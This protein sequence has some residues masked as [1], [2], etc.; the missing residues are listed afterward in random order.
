MELCDCF[1]NADPAESVEKTYV[2]SMIDFFTPGEHVNAC[3]KTCTMIF[4]GWIF[5]CQ[6]ATIIIGFEAFGKEFAV[7]NKH[8]DFVIQIN[9]TDPLPL[10][11]LCGTNAYQD[12][13]LDVWVSN[14]FSSICL[15]VWYMLICCCCYCNKNYLYTLLDFSYG[16][17]G[18]I[19]FIGF[20]IK[21][22]AVG[23]F[24]ISSDTCKQTFIDYGL[25]EYITLLN[26]E[27]NVYLPFFAIFFANYVIPLFLTL[28]YICVL[29]IRK[30]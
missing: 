6:I 20:I 4:S 5:I 13:L 29:L 17:Y 8:V 2:Y 25:G 24:Q 28:I 21:C 16:G 3:K 19:I 26:K 1:I 15:I 23:R 11:M 18:L 30:K 22:A 7:W 12:I 10:K 9:G 14:L 27:L